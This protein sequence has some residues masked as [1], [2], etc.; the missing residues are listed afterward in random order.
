ME[1]CAEIMQSVPMRPR[2]AQSG[3]FSG[4]FEAIFLAIVSI[5]LLQAPTRKT[6]SIARKCEERLTEQPQERETKEYPPSTR[7]NDDQRK[8]KC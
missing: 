3:R 1:K 7:V 5:P 2:S 8:K 6:R 4:I